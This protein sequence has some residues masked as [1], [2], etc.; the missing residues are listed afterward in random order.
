MRHSFKFILGLASIA[1]VGTVIYLASKKQTLKK[2]AQEVADEG[3][4]TA[5]DI[6]YPLG[7]RRTRYY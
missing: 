2:R 6:L 7:K 4:E 5:Y 1:L 3:Y